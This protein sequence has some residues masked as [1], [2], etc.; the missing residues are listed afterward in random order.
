MN[1]DAKRPGVEISIFA[2]SLTECSLQSVSLN[3]MS[4]VV[5]IMNGE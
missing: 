5:Y 2:H 4:C 1:Y 3:A